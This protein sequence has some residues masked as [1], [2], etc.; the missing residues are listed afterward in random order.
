MTLEGRRDDLLVIGLTGGI[1]SGKSLAA[2]YF[3]EC[4][5]AVIDTDAIAREVVAPGTVG[6]ERIRE[7]FG[8]DVIDERGELD[9]AAMRSRIFQDPAERQRLESI[10]HPLIEHA[11]RARLAQV[12]APY[13]ILVVPLLIESGWQ[14]LTDRVAVVDCPEE[15]QRQRL[16]ERDGTAPDDADRILASQLPRGERLARADDLLINDSTADALREQVRRLDAEY[17]HHGSAPA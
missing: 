13:A 9:R 3:A 6:L 17:R 15:Q 4:G 7:T 1:A 10:T 8:L 11:V 14:P 2:E 12:E 5:A 16:Y